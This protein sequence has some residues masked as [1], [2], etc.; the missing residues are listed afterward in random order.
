MYSKILIANRG[1]IAVRIIRACREMGIATVAVYSK[2]D[3][4]ALHTCLADECYCIG[5]SLVTDSYLNANAILTVAMH[6]GAEAIHPG[7]GM[8]SENSDFALLC[9]K[10]GIDFI[11]PD[12]EVIKKLGRK[13]Y[14]RNIAIKAGVPVAK[15]SG[16]LTSID[17]VY[18]FV[19]EVGFP[20][21]LKARSGGGGKGIRI[22]RNE[23]ELKHCYASVV[24]EAKNSFSD[25]KV[26]AE[27]YLERVKHI[28][29]QLIADKSGNVLAVGDRDCSMQRK[30]QKI[31]EEC[32]APTIDEKTREKLYSYAEKLAKTAHYTT[33]GTVEFLVTENSEVF[34]CEMNTRLQVEHTVTEEVTG[35]DIVKWQIRTSFGQTLDIPRNDLSYYHAIECRICAEDRKFL[36]S[37]GEISYVHIPGGMNIRFDTCILQGMKVTPFYDSMLGKL[38]VKG[39]D[40][41]DAIRKLKS[42]LNELIILGIDVNTKLH[43]ELIESDEFV[44]GE[45][46]TKFM[47]RKYGY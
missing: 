1:E 40:R 20:I 30:N 34:F 21:I 44:T 7:Y 25:D 27:K 15:G 43:L 37:C 14:A 39:N 5:K 32:P 17:K 6:T 36:P 19:R 47:E 23:A 38:I 42:A 10:N 41:E 22:V 31:I 9:K 28:E 13:D 4:E 11:G 3:K 16:I 29:V 33:V 26:F 46:D 8:L 24:E 18:D 45:Y 35:I 12:S 2:A